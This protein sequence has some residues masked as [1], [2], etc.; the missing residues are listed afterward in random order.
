MEALFPTDI[1]RA[2]LYCTAKPD[3]KRTYLQGVYITPTHIRATNGSALVAMEHGADTTIDAVFIV[4]GDIP[5]ESEGVLFT[6]YD[7]GWVAIHMDEDGEP[8]A[9]NVLQKIDCEYPDFS[10]V[11]PEKA[12]PC[13]EFPLFSARTLA[14]P[15]EMFKSNFGPVVFKPYGPT[16]PCEVLL[17]PVT[18]HLFGNPFMVIMPLQEDAFEMLEEVLDENRL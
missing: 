5:E 16:S 15:Y 1:L 6:L 4:R 7:D 18:R 2:A 11:L 8:F 17:D 9:S 12:E 3:D 14:L 13:K 10:K